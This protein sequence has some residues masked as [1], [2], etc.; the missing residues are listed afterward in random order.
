MV[1]IFLALSLIIPLIKGHDVN[2]CKS[3]QL[4]TIEESLTLINANGGKP[5]ITNLVD[6]HFPVYKSSIFTTL[7]WPYLSPIGPSGRFI[8]ICP[9]QSSQQVVLPNQ[10]SIQFSNDSSKCK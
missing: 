10:L 8:C 1:E 9:Q 5:N 2:Q 4:T 6:S 3:D 7:Q